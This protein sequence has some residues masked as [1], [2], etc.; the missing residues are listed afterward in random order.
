M[1]CEDCAWF[2]LEPEKWRTGACLHTWIPDVKVD[3]V[4]LYGAYGRVLTIQPACEDFR[5][6]AKCACTIEDERTNAYAGYDYKLSCG[7]TAISC[8]QFYKPSYCPDCGAKVIKEVD[9]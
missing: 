3:G 8:N 4:E 6:R 1:K 7:H 2:A 5:P 9:G